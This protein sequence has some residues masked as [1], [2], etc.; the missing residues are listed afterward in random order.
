MFL[1]YGEVDA[2]RHTVILVPLSLSLSS[3]FRLPRPH[4]TS[5]LHLSPR[6]LLNYSSQQL[7][8]IKKFEAISKKPEDLFSDFLHGFYK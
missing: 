6:S 4:I 7:P 3:N 2:Y 5:A 8:P 1:K